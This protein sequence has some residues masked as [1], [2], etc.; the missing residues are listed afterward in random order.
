MKTNILAATIA[1]LAV[2][3]TA[4]PK[5]VLAAEEYPN[6]QIRFV[7]P[8]PPGG[9]NDTVARVL[10]QKLSENMGQPV[11]VDNKPG[12]SGMI[13][14]EFV[15][16]SAP[17]GYTVMID[18]SSLVMNPALYPNS[19]FDVKQDLAPVTLVANMLHVLIVNPSV[20]ARDL[21]ELTALAK[22]QPGRLNYSSTGTGGPQH[23]LMEL[24]KRAAGIDIVH[25]PYKGGA[26]ATLAVLANDVQMT[27]ITVSTSLPH[28][29]AGKVRVIAAVGRERSK[30]LPDVPT[31]AE[32]GFKGLAT[33]W[34]GILAPLKT[35]AVIVKRLNVEFVAALN[36]AQVREKLEQQAF[37]VVG[38]TPE[39]FGKFLDDELALYGKLI[40]DVGIK[41][42]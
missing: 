34:L 14:G 17:D 39:A 5:S 11:V 31:F 19:K 12:A 36:S 20:L 33:P 22:A 3:G 40:R 26:P 7:V 32:S 9:A 16:K 21:A 29:K 25:V 10:A 24:F 2:A 18:Q 23:I 41:A 27:F 42:D 37:E 13:A 4:F 1:V 38:S 6:R 35:P 8:Y 15:A 28:I 30:I